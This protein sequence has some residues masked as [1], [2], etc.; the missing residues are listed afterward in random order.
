M[1]LPNKLTA[2]RRRFCSPF[3][4][5]QTILGGRRSLNDRYDSF[6]LDYSL[7][8]L[9]VQHNYIDAAKQVRV[10]AAGMHWFVGC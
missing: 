6:F 10:L 7:V 4:A 5:C 8:P 2:A 3:D 9:L 1:S